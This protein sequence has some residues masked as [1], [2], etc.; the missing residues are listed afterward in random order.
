MNE[1]AHNQNI[2]NLKFIINEYTK[3]RGEPQFLIM[4]SSCCREFIMIYQKDGP[5]PLK[6]CYFDRI[7]YPDFLKNLE[8]LNC[9]KCQSLIGEKM[10]YVKE[11]RIVFLN[12]NS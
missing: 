5:G 10:I 2:L 1:N 6:K 3:S 8:K 9:R 12:K 4:F 11:N 7:H